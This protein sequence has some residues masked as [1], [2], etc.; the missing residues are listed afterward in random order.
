MGVGSRFPRPARIHVRFGPAIA[1]PQG[2]SARDRQALG[3]FARRVAQAIRDLDPL[4]P[5]A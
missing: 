5:A 3:D 4:E 1:Y 2:R